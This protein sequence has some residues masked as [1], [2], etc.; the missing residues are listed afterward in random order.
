MHYLRKILWR[1]LPLILVLLVIACPGIRAAALLFEDN[2]DSADVRAWT[3]QYGKWSIV[4]DNG[5]GS[6]VFYQSS[7]NEGR[8]FTGSSSW[9]NYTVTAQVKVENFN[10]A[11]RVNLCARYRDGNNYYA[12]SLYNSKGGVLEL[13]K[14]VSGSSATLAAKKL[15][16]SSGVWYIMQLKVNGAN[17]S[18]AVNGVEQLS[19]TDNSFTS[20]G[21]GL[22]AY[23]AAAK[24]DEIVVNS[25]D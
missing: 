19:V 14:K 5:N 21:I 3:T 18:L 25:L 23:K 8:A 12:A 2:F 22:V 1:S 16:L 13:R 6:Y 20:G 4:Q 17:L 7:L 10:G 24:F 11:N 9:S 15:P